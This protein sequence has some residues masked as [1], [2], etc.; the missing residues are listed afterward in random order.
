MQQRIVPW[1][2]SIPWLLSSADLW[3]TSPVP[4]GFTIWLMLKC[5]CHLQSSAHPDKWSIPHGSIIISD[6]FRFSYLQPT[7]CF[8]HPLPEASPQGIVPCL[9]SFIQ[10]IIF[11]PLFLFLSVSHALVDNIFSTKKDKGPWSLHSLPNYQSL[12][13]HFSLPRAHDLSPELL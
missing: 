12:S 6:H 11:Q 5:F 9:F 4:W 8:N 1:V 7:F 13:I 3:E 10:T 2:S